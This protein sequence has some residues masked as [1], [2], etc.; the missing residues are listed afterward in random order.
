MPMAEEE[1]RRYYSALWAHCAAKPGAVEKRRWGETLFK[2][3][4]RVFAFMNSQARPAVTVKATRQEMPRLLATPSLARARYVG[5]FGWITVSVDDVR[6]LE[7]AFELI[8]R[9]YR[10]ATSG[11]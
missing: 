5:R 3:R 6:S 2:A 7:L 1:S 9:S 4:G 10:V 11:R 8:D